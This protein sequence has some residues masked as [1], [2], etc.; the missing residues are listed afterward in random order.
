MQ[1][2]KAVTLPFKFNKLPSYLPSSAVTVEA[3]NYIATDSDQFSNFIT[4]QHE[5]KKQQYESWINDVIQRDLKEKR[6]IA[7]GYLDSNNKILQPTKHET[8][9]K[10]EPKIKVED[11]VNEI[12]KVFGKVSL[13]DNRNNSTD[14]ES[15]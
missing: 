12:D 8:S 7:P 10:R 1:A 5:Q 11:E 9:T 2:P 3:V 6:K 15:Y 14:K 13:S 4:K